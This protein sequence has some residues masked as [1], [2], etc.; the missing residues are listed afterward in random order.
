MAMLDKGSENGAVW[1]LDDRIDTTL[2]PRNR[3]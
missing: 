1:S 2:Q 3:I